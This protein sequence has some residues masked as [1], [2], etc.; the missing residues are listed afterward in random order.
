MEKIKNIAPWIILLLYLLVAFVLITKNKADIACKKIYISIKNQEKNRFIEEKDVLAL[1]N[2]EHII[3]KNIEEINLNEI[4]QKI[5]KHTN[6]KEA[7]V[8]RNINGELKIEIIQRKPIV[9]IINKNQSAYFIDEEGKLMPLSN[10]YT[11]NVLIVNGEIDEPYNKWNKTNFMI[12]KEHIVKKSESIL[13]D[14]FLLA[15][16]IYRDDFWNTQIEQIYVKNNEFEMIP[17]VGSQT[18][19]FGDISHYEKK[20]EKLKALYEQGMSQ[21]GWNK[22]KKI[23][24]KYNKQ[25]ICTKL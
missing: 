3:G 19:V 7:N 11:P 20:F 5:A 8:F 9:R 2:K 23:N 12:K 1:L 18:I 6:I 13:F 14:L 10:K 24:L 21:V 17:R 16:Y 22:Y 25:V 15:N 4:E